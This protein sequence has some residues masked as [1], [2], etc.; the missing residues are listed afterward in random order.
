MDK[1]KR[2]KKTGNE[3][4][5]MVGR[6]EREKIEWMKIAGRKTR[7]EM[8][9]ESADVLSVSPTSLLAPPSYAY[10]TLPINPVSDDHLL[11]LFTRIG[12]V[13]V[14]DIV[15]LSFIPHFFR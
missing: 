15:V 6:E 14:V 8:M 4:Q 2:G 10:L 5:G 7:R 9:V 3:G 13:V 12:D 1:R 11:G